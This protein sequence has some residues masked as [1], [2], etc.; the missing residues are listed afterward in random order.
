MTLDF[1]GV[2]GT[3]PC[4]HGVL[5]SSQFMVHSVHCGLLMKKKKLMVRMQ[6]YEVEPAQLLGGEMKIS[7]L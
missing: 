4:L 6:F 3:V 5:H 7:D 2:I 1:R